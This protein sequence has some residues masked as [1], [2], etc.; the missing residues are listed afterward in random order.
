MCI[1]NQWTDPKAACYL[2]HQRHQFFYDR[3][4][5][6]MLPFTLSVVNKREVISMNHPYHLLWPLEYICQWVQLTQRK[7]LSIIHSFS[8]I[9]LPKW[10]F[11]K[12]VLGNPANQNSVCCGLKCIWGK[13]R[14]K[15]LSN[16]SAHCG[17]SEGL[18]YTYVKEERRKQKQKQKNTTIDLGPFKIKNTA[19]QWFFKTF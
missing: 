7:D 1:R 8:N 15:G 9:P 19:G 5:D 17:P 12:Y 6:L 2:I 14:K 16:K 18:H 11:L 3:I 4:L 13:M 10:H